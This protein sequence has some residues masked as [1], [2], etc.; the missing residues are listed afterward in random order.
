MLSKIQPQQALM[1]VFAIGVLASFALV[2]GAVV[3]VAWLI[4][5]AMTAICE[6]SNTIGA[7]YS[8]SDSIVKLLIIAALAYCLASAVRVGAKLWKAGA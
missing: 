1:A 6:A 4:T 5:L 8:G 7:L 2:I 3:A